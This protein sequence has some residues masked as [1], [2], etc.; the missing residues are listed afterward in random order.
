MAKI[1]VRGGPLSIS[2]HP[3]LETR[4]RWRRGVGV[5]SSAVGQGRGFGTLHGSSSQKPNEN[6]KTIDLFTVASKQTVDG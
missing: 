5:G 6:T 1:E 2:G 4:H 3:P